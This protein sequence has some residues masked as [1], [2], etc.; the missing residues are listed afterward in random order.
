MKHK[1]GTFFVTGFCSIFIVKVLSISIQRTSFRL[2]LP[3][4]ASGSTY[5]STCKT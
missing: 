4:R 5:P 2:S 3:K 1:S